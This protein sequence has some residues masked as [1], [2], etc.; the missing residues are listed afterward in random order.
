MNPYELAWFTSYEI[1]KKKPG[2]VRILIRDE[3]QFPFLGKEEDRFVIFLPKMKKA[4]ENLVAYQ[5][6]LFNLA[7]AN[8]LRILWTL[9]KASVYYLSFY[10]AVSDIGLY[11]EWV[12]GKDEEAALYA[13]T[14]VEDAAINAYV[15]AFYSPFLPEMKIGDAVSY[16]MLKP[17]EALR[18]EGLRFAASTLT[19]YKVS[20][21]K[22]SLPEETMRDVE[23]TVSVVKRFEEGMLKTYLERKEREEAGISPILNGPEKLRAASAVYEAVS[24]HGS[25]SEIPSFLYMNHMDR[26]SIFYRT[27]PSKEELEKT[28]EKIKSGMSLKIDIDMESIEREATQALWDWDRKNKSKEKIIAKYRELGKGTHFKSFTFPEEDYARYLLRKE[29]LSKGIRRVLNRLSVYYNVAGEDFR[30]ESGYLDLQEAIQVIASQ[31]QRSDVFVEDELRYRKQAWVILVDASTS[32]KAFSGEVRDIALSLAEV[33]KNLFLDKHSWSIFAFND[34]FYIIKDF[35][36]NYS[37][38]VCARIGGIEHSGMTYLPDAIKVS[39]DSLRE[40]YE[41]TKILLVVSDAFPVGYRNIDEEL[42]NQVRTV[43]RSGIHVLGIGVN[44][45]GVKK[46]FPVSCIVRNPYELMKSFVKAFFQYM[47]MM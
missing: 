8:D 9:F 34:R 17:A 1:T 16:L 7:D 47:S 42:R 31:S 41:E 27:L 21:V 26:N 44:S 6:M 43:I 25:L 18:S 4:K 30:R 29:V 10:I 14:L 22:G 13:V 35:S 38:I 15:K 3:V 11:P 37:R 28:V 33:A 12:K 20:M 46:Y 24:S 32:L 5:G 45:E 36:E 2:E 40:R 39:S 23:A 19:Y